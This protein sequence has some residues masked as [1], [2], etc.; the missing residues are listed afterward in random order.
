MGRGIV[1]KGGFYMDL[2]EQTGSA[3]YLIGFAVLFNALVVSFVPALAFTLTLLV[4]VVC[5][6]I[7]KFD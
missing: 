1:F 4:L 5:L 3:G 2:L 7:V 6:V